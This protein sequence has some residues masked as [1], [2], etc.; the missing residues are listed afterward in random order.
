MYYTLLILVTLSPDVRENATLSQSKVVLLAAVYNRSQ[1]GL[2]L[3]GQIMCQSDN[4]LLVSES[5]IAQS[6]LYGNPRV[7]DFALECRTAGS[8]KLRLQ[9][10]SQNAARA[11]GGADAAEAAAMPLQKPPPSAACTGWGV[12]GHANGAGGLGSAG[13]AQRAVCST[14]V[15]GACEGVCEKEPALNR[16]AGESAY[17][18]AAEA[19][20]DGAPAGSAARNACA[21][22]GE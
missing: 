10:S 1:W 3:V 7:P 21:R 20:P 19:A 15:A 14:S 16:A 12:K 6:C 22:E 17:V 9:R 8:T 11:N 13:T 5:V 2:L 18:A 4:S